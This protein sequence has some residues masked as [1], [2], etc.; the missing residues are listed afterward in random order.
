MDARIFGML[1]QVYCRIGIRQT[2]CTVGRLQACLRGDSQVVNCVLPHPSVS[3]IATA[4]IDHS[5]KM[6][7][8]TSRDEEKE[9][10][11]EVRFLALFQI[12]KWINLPDG[13][14]RCAVNQQ[15]MRDGPLTMSF[16][17]AFIEQLRDGQI[18]FDDDQ[19]GEEIDVN[20][21]RTT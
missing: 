15:R 17:M 9:E 10:D 19:D 4:G 7:W 3:L 2:G 13:L 11:S 16:P 1:R 20:A 12:F 18:M 6:W 8:A 14:R 5:I 21:C